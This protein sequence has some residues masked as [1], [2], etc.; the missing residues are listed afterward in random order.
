[1][2]R[3]EDY[4][5]IGD[6][7]TAALVSTAGS[8]DWL[9]LP[10]FDSPACFAA[11]LDDE[12][13]GRWRLAAE[14]AEECTRRRYLPATLVLETT[15]RTADGEVRVLDLM[16]P[17]GQAADVVRIVEGVSGTVRMRSDLRLRFA[18][19]AVMPW[20]RHTRQ[21]MSAV[22]GPDAAYLHT[23]VP[24]NGQDWSTVAEFAVAAGDRVP[25]VLTWAAG[26]LPRPRAVDAEDALTDTVAFWQHLAFLSGYR[27]RAATLTSWP[28]T[29]AASN[30][31][32]R[33][34]PTITRPAA[35]LAS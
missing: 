28:V 9:C 12:G 8:V 4:A 13:A 22:A 11:L 23:P 30:R 14:G 7:H 20:V 18:D 10:R 5:M 33:A 1:M 3:I 16:P 6:L 17:R 32:E 34:F 15:W 35:D 25:F 31:R 24:V 2:A 29:L 21:G 26:H 19:G 27:N